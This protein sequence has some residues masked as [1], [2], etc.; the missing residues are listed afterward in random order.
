MTS[1]SSAG[2]FLQNDLLD[3]RFESLRLLV[4][5]YINVMVYCDPIASLSDLKESIERHVRNIP[6]CML[7]S[8]VEHA[9]LRFQMVADN[10]RQNIEHVL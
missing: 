6:Q 5:G 8:T 7:L 9:I 3:P 2:I 1:E 4:V 10:G